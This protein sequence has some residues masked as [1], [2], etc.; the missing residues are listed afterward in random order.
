MNALTLIRVRNL[1]SYFLQSGWQRIPWDHLCVGDAFAHGS[2][3]LTAHC[4]AACAN[5]TSPAYSNPPSPRT[6]KVPCKTSPAALGAP[7]LHH[8]PPYQQSRIIS[9]AGMKEPNCIPSHHNLICISKH[10]KSIMSFC[11]A[12]KV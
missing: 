2:G 9:H 8:G 10:S 1:C 4:L 12:N 3:R 6:P 11:E 7:W 5:P